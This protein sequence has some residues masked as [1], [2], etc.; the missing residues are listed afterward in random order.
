MNTIQLQ[1]LGKVA[2]TEA[3]N[4][5][6]GDVTVWNYG[7]LETITSIEFSK[8]GKTLTAGIEYFDTFYNKVV[9]ST[10]KFKATRI[11]GIQN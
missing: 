5:K 10:R 6:V 8:T 3:Q 9:Q 2:A 1:G 7:G 11:V 4:L